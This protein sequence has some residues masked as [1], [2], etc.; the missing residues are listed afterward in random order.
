MVV[1]LTE[2]AKRII[3]N[4]PEKIRML[5]ERAGI[6]RVLHS[7]GLQVITI[8]EMNLQLNMHIEEHY[9]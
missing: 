1:E 2:Y 4:N 3:A 6:G 8:K 5:R 9:T 7:C